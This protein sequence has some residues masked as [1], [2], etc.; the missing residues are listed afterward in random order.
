MM[1]EIIVIISQ[2]ISG[3]TINTT[4]ASWTGLWHEK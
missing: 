4:L 3:N 1:L 2:E